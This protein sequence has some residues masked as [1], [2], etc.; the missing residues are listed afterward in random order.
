MVRQVTY[1]PVCFSSVEYTIQL[2]L[3]LR[4]GNRENILT[5]ARNSY[6]AFLHEACQRFW[7]IINAFKSL[8]NRGLSLWRIFRE[9]NF[10]ISWRHTLR[11]V[12]LLYWRWKIPEALGRRAKSNRVKPSQH[13]CMFVPRPDVALQSQCTDRWLTFNLGAI[14]R[15][16]LGQILACSNTKLRWRTWRHNGTGSTA[17]LACWS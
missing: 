9:R 7:F 11:Q 2:S 5:I 3:A 4:T 1:F 17:V 13:M 15:S 6:P 8:N 10:H 14:V 16:N 12:A